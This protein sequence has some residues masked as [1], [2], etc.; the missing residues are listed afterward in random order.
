[1]FRFPPTVW[2]TKATMRGFTNLE[3]DPPDEF[4]RFFRK[5]R[6]KSIG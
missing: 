3:L 6:E 5:E 1:M 4:L 2:F